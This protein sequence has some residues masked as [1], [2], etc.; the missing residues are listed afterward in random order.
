MIFMSESIKLNL[1][2]STKQHLKISKLKK[3]QKINNNEKKKKINQRL[4]S[5]ESR[6]FREI[7]HA[8]ITSVIGVFC[9]WIQRKIP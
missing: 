3:P 5:V 7:F 4:I 8:F 2:W 6:W 9:T 1:F